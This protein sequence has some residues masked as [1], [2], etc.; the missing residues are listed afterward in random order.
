[1]SRASR[2]AR[3]ATL[4]DS[5]SASVRDLDAQRV[6]EPEARTCQFCHQPWPKN[7]PVYDFT[8]EHL[9]GE[10]THP[11]RTCSCFH[12]RREYGVQSVWLP[13]I[14]RLDVEALRKKG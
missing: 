4:C 13:E 7:G 2:N 6:A 9:S 11:S 14:D 3:V 10:C 12:C 8:R 5:R 1:M